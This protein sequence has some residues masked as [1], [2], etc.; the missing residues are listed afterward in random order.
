MKYLTAIFA[1]IAAITLSNAQDPPAA[2]I[3]QSVIDSLFGEHP[4]IAS[5][6]DAIEFA[7]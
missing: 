4:T 5:F 7:E 1:T 2:E 6:T 3:D